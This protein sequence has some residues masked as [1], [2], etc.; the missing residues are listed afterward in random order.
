[1]TDDALIKEIEASTGWHEILIAAQDALVGMGTFELPL[2]VSLIG[3][4]YNEW[5][6]ERAKRIV[7]AVL[8]ML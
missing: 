6:H 2:D 4:T 8:R 3:M 1:M 5:Q 7:L